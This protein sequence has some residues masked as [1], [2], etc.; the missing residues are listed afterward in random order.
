MS[1]KPTPV[2][3]VLL[4]YRCFSCGA[5]PG[6][7]CRTSRGYLATTLHSSRY[8]QARSAGTLPLKDPA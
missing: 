6:H 4:R 3:V 7:W 5:M 2:D 1:E 8:W